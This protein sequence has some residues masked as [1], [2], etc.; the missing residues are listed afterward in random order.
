[1][2]GTAIIAP[3]FST[4]EMFGRMILLKSIGERVVVGAVANNALL[5]W[6]NFYDKANDFVNG[7]FDLSTGSIKNVD[8]PIIPHIGGA[9]KITDAFT[10][11]AMGFGEFAKSKTEMNFDP[12]GVQI[13]SLKERKFSNFGATV[14]ATISLGK[15]GLAPRFTFSMPQ[16]A[17]KDRHI[18]NVGFDFASEEKLMLW[19]GSAAWFAGF[20][21][22]IVLGLWGKVE[23]Y[24][25]SR[26][27]VENIGNT[28]KYTSP[29][30]KNHFVFGFC[31]TEIHLNDNFMMSPEYDF[32][33]AKFYIT[34][35]KDSS[36]MAL[37]DTTQRFRT[38][39]FRFGFEGKVGGKKFFDVMTGRAGLVY[40]VTSQQTIWMD[41]TGKEVFVGSPVVQTYDKYNGR[42]GMKLAAGFGLT[43]KRATLDLSADLLKWESGSSLTGPRA[44]MLTVT[45]D[46]AR[47]AR[48]AKIESSEPAEE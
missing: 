45:I 29:L 6:G 13:D 24:Q 37:K 47:N 31:G 46:I 35:A 21:Y 7:G 12:A 19:F 14:D 11:G 32:E 42:N 18:T 22:P 48:Y 16:V 34:D 36:G 17:G 30:Y 9:F 23:N 10:I 26:A 41:S 33:L 38:H 20:K 15:F 2:Q 27:P 3:Y 44:A 43:K 1:V 8:L 4:N 40:K 39:T 25:F 5:M 28:I